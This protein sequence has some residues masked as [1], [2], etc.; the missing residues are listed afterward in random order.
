MVGKLENASL[1][2]PV[3]PDNPQAALV[4]KLLVLRELRLT[5]NLAQRFR[6]PR[7]G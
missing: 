4:E 2:V 5:P 1:A 7:Q 3:H 6:A